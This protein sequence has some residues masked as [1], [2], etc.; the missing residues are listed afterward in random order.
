MEK[1]PNEAYRLLMELEDASDRIDE[2]ED[3]VERL[4][5]TVTRTNPLWDTIQT[6]MW[7]KTPVEAL[8]E[9]LQVLPPSYVGKYILEMEKAGLV[10]IND[11]RESG[12]LPCVLKYLDNESRHCRMLMEEYEA[13]HE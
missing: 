1:T 12:Y 8:S 2:L 6:A 3:Q 5:F 13:A 7:E 11:V 9:R 4:S 10:T